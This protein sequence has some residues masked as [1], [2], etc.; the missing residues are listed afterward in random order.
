MWGATSLTG[1]P[2]ARDRTDPQNDR[3]SIISRREDRQLAPRVIPFKSAEPLH[4]ASEKRQP[5]PPELP[6]P[7]HLLKREMDL[8]DQP[9]CKKM[10]PAPPQLPP[11][12]HL[13]KKH[14]VDTQ[15]VHSKFVVCRDDLPDD[16]IG[17]MTFDTVGE[18][19]CW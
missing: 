18:P 13:L 11:P 6:P 15:Q 4:T 17:I 16:L 9:A 1:F 14:E 8:P 12:L 19:P 10:R 5:A 7:E 2:A 3:F